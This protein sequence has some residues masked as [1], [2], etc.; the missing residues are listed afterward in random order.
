MKKHIVI[1]CLFLLGIQAF[2][3]RDYKPG[4]VVTNQGDTINGDI[5]DEGGIYNS[6]NCYFKSATDSLHKN[7]KPGEIKAYR[8][9]NGKYFVSRRVVLDKQEKKVFLEFLVDGKAD[10][11]Y[12]APKLFFIEKN[13]EKMQVLQS[14]EKIFM[15]NSGD[16][17]SR[18]L[19]EYKG[20]MCA[21]LKDCPE[22]YY[23]ISNSP[24]EQS[25]LIVITAEY[26]KR[27]CP[28][29]ECI[30]YSKKP[31]KYNTKLGI[32]GGINRNEVKVNYTYTDET[33]TEMSSGF[34]AGIQVE[35]S[36]IGSHERFFTSFSFLYSQVKHSLSFS[37]SNLEY[38]SKNIFI[39]G[40]YNYR[41]PR[42]KLKP[43][44][45]VGAMHFQ[46]LRS[47]INKSVKFE[48]KTKKR[49]IGPLLSGGLS[50]DVDKNVSF[51]L[52]I[53]YLYGIFNY[54]A[55]NYFETNTNNLNYMLSV[56]YKLTKE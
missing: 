17:Y 53:N 16:L 15:R 28:D 51:K 8:F 52:E 34:L 36:T 4:F 13:G 23:K 46:T 14:T 41:Y 19:K 11:Y 3:Q 56:Q 32:V 21:Y 48:Y 39:G 1:A 43:F 6:E 25:N 31:P 27:I 18:E 49:S 7:F 10:L 37:Y 42:Y 2:A 22:L 5:D 26:N 12:L 47:S 44:I 29:E 24:F 35:S 40:A 30:I 45:G 54:D 9:T 38:L 20:I 50:C 55:D 33:R